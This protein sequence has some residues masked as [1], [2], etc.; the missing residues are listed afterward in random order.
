MPLADSDIFKSKFY[1][2]YTKNKKEKEFIDDWKE[3]EKI[4][5]DISLTHGVDDFFAN[6][7]YYLRAKDGN[8]NTSVIALRAFYDKKNHINEQT[9]ENIKILANFWSEIKDEKGE[10]DD[11]ISKN[12]FILKYAP[13]AMW[14]F[15]VSVYFMQNKDENGKLD[16]EKFAEFLDK[17]IAFSFAYEITKPGVNA[18]R[19]PF[20]PEMVKIVKNEKVDFANFKFDE[21]NFKEV[22]MTT[23]FGNSRGITRAIL[24]WWLFEN[25]Q[26]L[27]EIKNEKLDIEHI[28]AKKLY[29]D[30][31]SLLKNERNLESLGNKV[32]LE[33]SINIPARDYHFCDKK[34]WYLGELGKKKRKTKIAEILKIVSK[35]ENL[36][37][38]TEEMIQ[39]RQK[40]ILDKFI[41][42][43][44]KNNLIK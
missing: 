23:N 29:E 33:N 31:S 39:N 1:A 26:D 10:F 42:N 19:A 21:A 44:R 11:D 24:T 34:K 43:L 25:N 2:I 5:K 17:L 12:L 4:A 20:F 40:L 22:F 30:D 18:L 7:M 38:F 35:N 13:N 37:D 15:M 3:L 27:D 41:E 36:Q 6:Y 16:E 32:L 8:T 14:E 28:L 9:F